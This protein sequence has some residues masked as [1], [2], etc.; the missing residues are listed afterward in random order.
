MEEDCQH[1]GEEVEDSETT[2]PG[3]AVVGNELMMHTNG[4]SEQLSEP[5]QTSETAKI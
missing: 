4:T 3:E 1:A 2:E 5:V